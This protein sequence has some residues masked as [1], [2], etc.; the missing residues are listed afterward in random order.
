M[1]QPPTLDHI[2][3]L[4]S[5]KTLTNL[6]AI[7]GETFTISPGGKHNSGLTWN[8][9]VLFKDGVYI[10]FIAFFD[11]VD[12]I[13][14]RAHRWGNLPEN[15]IIDWAF[16]SLP[17]SGKGVDFDEIR[18]HVNHVSSGEIVYEKPAEWSRKREDGV[19]LEWTLSTPV[20]SPSSGAGSGSG[21][22]PGKLPFWCFDTTPRSLRVPYEDQPSLTEH[23]S[24]VSGVS[25]LKLAFD[26]VDITRLGKVY[27]VL[28]PSVEDSG[29]RGVW[30]FGVPGG[31]QY[32]SIST[33]SPG[34]GGAGAGAGA[35]IVLTLKGPVSRNV[36]ILPGLVIQIEK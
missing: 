32:G 19:L 24:G 23:P 28:S 13:K 29:E 7:L 20:A 8:K 31:E 3:I 33:I 12:P 1:P 9:L 4:T 35:S 2:V 6:P 11:D 10:E 30:K 15:T 25:S 5:N 36:E 27:D 21:L 18:E 26:A 16:T 14:R 22:S 17:E 34:D